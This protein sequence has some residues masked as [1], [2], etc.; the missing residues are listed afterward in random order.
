MISPDRAIETAMNKAAVL[1]EMVSLLQETLELEGDHSAAKASPDSP[2]IGSDAIVASLGLVS[3][4]SDVERW[5]SDERGVEV[6]LVS[7]QAMSRTQSPFRTVEAL[8]DYVLELLAEP[9]N[10]E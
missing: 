4:I 3:F 7:E 8:A 5:L 1:T 2:L 9:V 6:T 10:H